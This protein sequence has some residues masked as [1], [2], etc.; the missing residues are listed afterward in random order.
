MFEVDHTQSAGDSMHA[1]IENYTK[2]KSI[3]TQKELA[4][5]IKECKVEG[6]Y[7]V[8]EIT[9]AN[10]FD[11]DAV[12]KLFNWKLAKVSF[13]REINIL[14]KSSFFDIKA[15][16]FKESKQINVLRRNVSLQNVID[17]QLTAAFE[18]QIPLNEK[19]KK[20]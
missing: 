6:S 13:V 7:V 19:K 3:F 5:Q 12:V 4:Q 16:Y 17:Y 11:F 14:H 9:Q 1:Q 15:N 2:N 18:K 10:I 20:I 8:R